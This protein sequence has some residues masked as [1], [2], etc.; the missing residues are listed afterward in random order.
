MKDPIEHYSKSLRYRDI[1]NYIVDGRLSGNVNTQKKIAGE[2]AKY[3]IVNGL[4][5][6]IGQ[7]KESGK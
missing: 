3:I 6:K 5:F 7:H 1:Y 4:L 2:A